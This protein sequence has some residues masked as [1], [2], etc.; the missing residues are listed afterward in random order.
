MI[1]C[2][3]SL[4]VQIF[5]ES[6]AHVKLVVDGELVAKVLE[7]VVE[8]AAFEPV[9]LLGELFVS[10]VFHLVNES[11]LL[12]QDLLLVFEEVF[13][14]LV[15]V[16]VFDVVDSKRAKMHDTNSGDHFEELFIVIIFFT[17]LLRVHVRLFVHFLDLVYQ[18][19]D[20]LR[21]FV[22]HEDE[23]QAIW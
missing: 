20:R 21:G 9:V 15:D 19:L 14:A 2:V 18:L 4:L 3:D 6:D 22:L 11:P 1:D 7:E 8:V 12:V 16:N 23:I 13:D 10:V 5:E 17:S